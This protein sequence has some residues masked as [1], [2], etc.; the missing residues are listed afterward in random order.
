MFGVLKRMTALAGEY[1]K[2]LIAA[3]VISVFEAAAEKIPVFMILYALIKIVDQTLN[4]TH[5]FIVLTTVL[6]SLLVTVIF[7][8]L[9]DKNQSGIGVLIF[10]RERLK[11]GDKIKKFPMSYFTEDNIGNLSAVVSSD[12]KFI[13]E[14]GMNQLAKITTSVISLIIT[15]VMMAVFSPYVA[16]IMMITCLLVG[17]VFIAIQKIAKKHSFQIQEMQKASTSAVIE[18]I[19]GMQVIKAFHLVGDTQNRTNVSY[20]NLSN[21]QFEYERNFIVP[22]V[23]AETIIAV[24]IGGI[25]CFASISVLNESMNLSMMLML[26]I[27][28]FEIYRPLNSLVSNSA[29][30]RVMEACMDRYEKAVNEPV[31]WD[32]KKKTEI[33][34]SDIE[35]QN[36]SFSYDSKPVI[37]NMSFV[38][39]EK[40]MTALVGI[41]GCG[42]TT[43]TN[44]I[45]RFWD[46]KEGKI[47]IGGV[48]IYDMAYEQLMSNISMVFQ[49]V[50]LFQDTIYNN[51]AFGNINATK[52]QVITAAKKARCYEFIQELPEG[53]DTQIGE[54]GATLSGGEK[55]R[56][57]I[58][59]AILKDAPIVLLDEATASV[60]PDNEHYIQEAISEL[61]TNKTLL[62]IAHKLS[63]IKAADQI[64][65]IE[66]GRISAA[67][68]H[69]E[70]STQKGLYQRLWKKNVRSMNFKL[71]GEE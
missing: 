60:D 61:V 3:Y 29:E 64:L 43:V 55:Q 53:F 6:G 69:K 44:L 12:M 34:N 9:R 21:S 30:I 50:Y 49:K 13:E 52:E 18:Y 1:K 8:Y 38:A 32:S 46:I 62:V 40:S 31:I 59:R 15:M 10:A 4:S 41:S 16:F 56:I 67:G 19:K 26:G 66:E 47:L 25:I 14:Q 35:F 24:S 63:T 68:T 28:A 65:V 20:R 71:K 42:K 7:R 54:G 17:C 48:N 33:L 36:V 22:M 39:K 57:S 51:I 27:F 23:I 37:Q 58:A 2:N 5:F 45:A 70:L 11:L